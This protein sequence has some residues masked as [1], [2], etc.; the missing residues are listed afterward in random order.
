MKKYLLAGIASML[1][2]SNAQAAGILTSATV[3]GLT[4]SQQ[5]GVTVW[6][7]DS[8][9]SYYALF[10]QH[11]FGVIL[12][13]NDN[14][15]GFVSSAGDNDFLIS[16]DGFP[17]VTGSTPANS[18]DRQN[19]NPFYRLTLTFDDGAVITGI[20]DPSTQTFIS[21]G[22]STV[23]GRTYTLNDFGFSRAGANIVSPF[24][25]VPGNSLRDY[26]GEFSFSVAVP[27]PATWG[28]MILGFGAIGGAMRSSRRKTALR[29]A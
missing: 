27:E 23:A 4:A 8:T 16:G 15:T 1:M 11:P 2:V 21:G 18:P 25:S 28:M 26:V 17:T 6:N 3:N 9:D 13:P 7:T 5:N 14:F 20:A 24:Q 19:S 29:L 12:N 10:L 22:S